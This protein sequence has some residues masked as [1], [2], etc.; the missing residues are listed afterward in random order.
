MRVICVKKPRIGDDGRTDHP[1]PEV[2]DEDI[3]I[4]NGTKH[5]KLY[6]KLG[7]FPRRYGYL[8]SYF[9]TLPDSTA[10]EMAEES[11][12]AIINSETV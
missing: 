4:G 3:V 11:K 5:G 9:A 2:G 6:Y 12:E 1:G 10:D 8:S 7:R